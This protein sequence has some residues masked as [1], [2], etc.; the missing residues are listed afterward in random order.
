MNAASAIG[1]PYDPRAVANAILREC[2]IAD[3]P[4]TNLGLQKLIYFAHGL[5]LIRSEG[6]PLIS[7]HFEA[8]TY[9]P[10]HP[11]V[12]SAFKSAGSQPILAPAMAK[13]LRTGQQSDIPLPEDRNVNRIIRLTVDSYGS[14]SVGQ[15][16]HLSH[17]KDGPWDVVYKRSQSQRM[18]GLRI[19]N[20]LI[21]ERFKFH[22]AST[23]ELDRIGDFDGFED[24]P[25]AHHGLG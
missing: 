14:F 13:N 7:G 8:W 5:F 20:E 4:I 12:Y 3:Q 6:R 10:V 22:K 24:T 1:A 19:S 9:G 11:A 23:C 25:L 16:V 2:A 21:S 18:L 15:L 17:A